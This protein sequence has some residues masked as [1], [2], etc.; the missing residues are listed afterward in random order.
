MRLRLDSDVNWKRIKC[1]DFLTNCGN[2]QLCEDQT[3][4]DGGEGLVSWG[5]DQE[6]QS[7][8]CQGQL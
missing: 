4:H 7:Q 5:K 2:S 1:I 6:E 3:V 8:N